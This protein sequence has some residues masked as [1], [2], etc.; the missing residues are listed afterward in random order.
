VM[1]PLQHQTWETF[2]VHWHTDVRIA[3]NWLRDALLK[4]V[5]GP[6]RPDRGGIP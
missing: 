1:R 2:S 4:R 6:L 5:R 3:F